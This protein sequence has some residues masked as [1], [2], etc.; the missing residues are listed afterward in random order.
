MQPDLNSPREELLSA[1]QRARVLSGSRLQ[2]TLTLSVV[3]LLGLVT[4][5]MFLAVDRIFVELQPRLRA[6]LE[7][8]ATANAAHLAQVSEVQIAAEDKEGL[9]RVLA[10]TADDGDV[11]GLVVTDPDGDE[12]ASRGSVA[13]SAGALFGGQRGAAQE[14]AGVLHAWQAA[15]IEG[16]V[17]GRVA[18]I[19][20]Q[21]RLRA[22]DRLRREIVERA[23]IGL[24]L[25]LA[26]SLAFVHFRLGPILKVTSAAFREL[27]QKTRQA[28]ES[29]RLKSEFLANMS[30]E[31]RTPMNGILGM[32]ELLLGTRLEARQRRYAET[33]RRSAEAL[34]TILNDVLDF[35]K[36]EAGK[37]SLSGTACDPREVLEEVAELMAAQAHTKGLELAVHVQSEVPARIY[38]DR[39]RL[40]QVVTNLSGNAVKFTDRGEVVLRASW[41]ADAL[42]IEVTDTGVGISGADRQRLFEPFWQADGSLTRRHGGT[43]LGLSICRKLV[44]LMGG[45]LGVDSEI[46]RGS[47]FWFTVAA[48]A[49]DGGAGGF[50]LPPLRALVVDDNATNRAILEETL[51]GWGLGVTS[52]ATPGEALEALETRPDAFDLVLTDQQMPDLDG[53]E[54]CRR[55]RALP[56]GSRFGIV[57]LS[58]LGHAVSVAAGEDPPFDHQLAKPT[59]QADL[60]RAIAQVVRGS[61]AAVVA[62]APSPAPGER[63][64]LGLRLLVAEDN[65]VNQE[66]ARE[67]LEELGCECVLAP[68]G[69]IALEA[70]RR[71]RFDAVLMDC[72]MP[73]LDGY[74]AA[75]ALRARERAEALPRTVV[76][77]V[78]AHALVGDREKALDAGMDDYVTKPLR[79]QDLLRAL[80]PLARSA[81]PA[82]EPALDPGVRRSPRVI[83]LFLQHTPPL[84]D[85]LAEAGS[86]EDAEGVRRLAHKLKGSA[87]AVGATA[88][89]AAARGLEHAAAEGAERIPELRA[90]FDEVALALRSAQGGAQNDG[91]PNAVRSRQV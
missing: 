26:L 84:L 34:L 53:V 30:H 36:I 80:E 85:E 17:I 88:L 62:R 57:L 12:L 22:G 8:K 58:S 51:R 31:I 29:T 48:P 71:E 6:D 1:E 77:A 15:E 64:K 61:G 39:E 60:R 16:E 40:R 45:D 55:I 46:G 90:R 13:V 37:L 44:Q 68:D 41:A 2:A 20:S 21:E 7:R 52:F 43:G 5:G 87:G 82:E 65:P 25:A 59:R 27:E 32:T 56:G 10:R 91:A 42:R 63:P 70:L 81:P 49:V 67:M 50:E 4:A 33:V 69:A 78:T 83:E 23:A 73:N 18:V 66:V 19:V 47:T 11:I 28:L 35:S 76:V 3:V 74:A 75:R 9:A 89:A 54:L 14:T 24:L 79:Q 86:R 72:Q 38:C